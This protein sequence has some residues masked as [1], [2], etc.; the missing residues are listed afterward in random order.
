MIGKPAIYPFQRLE[1][2][3]EKAMLP[4]TLLSK[5]SSTRSDLRKKLE[6]Q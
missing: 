2:P 4:T 6:Q 1:L 5:A 3:K